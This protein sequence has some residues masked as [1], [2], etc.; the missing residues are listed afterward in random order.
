MS[1]AGSVSQALCEIGFMRELQA[2]CIN[3]PTDKYR[4]LCS[5]L[6]GYFTVLKLAAN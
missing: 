2:V 4:W 5:F 6:Q 3:E 1:N